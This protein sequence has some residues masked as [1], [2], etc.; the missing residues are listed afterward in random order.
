MYDTRQSVT[1][2]VTAVRLHL[3]R[4]ACIILGYI[5][6]QMSLSP[7]SGLYQKSDF[8][9]AGGGAGWRWGIMVKS[10]PFNRISEVPACHGSKYCKSIQLK[11]PRVRQNRANKR[12]F[13]CLHYYYFTT[14]KDVVISYSALTGKWTCEKH[15]CRYRGYLQTNVIK[16]LI[17]PGNSNW[18]WRAISISLMHSMIWTP[19][20]L[21]IVTRKLLTRSKRLEV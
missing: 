11:C 21:L 6:W 14:E 13:L 18:R 3:G 4:A 8:W 20:R 15:V 17:F 9:A 2:T 1:Q 10:L 5:N 19:Q 12:I 7:D 16:R